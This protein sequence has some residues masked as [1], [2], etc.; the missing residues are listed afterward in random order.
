MTRLLVSVRDA[1]EARIAIAGGCDIIDLKEPHAGPLGACT[2]EVMKEVIDEVAGRVPI[3]AACGE[4]VEHGSDFTLLKSLPEGLKLAKI[5]PAQCIRESDISSELPPNELH[6]TSRL[7]AGWAALPR[8]IGRV[9]VAYADW[10]D[11]RAP[12]PG[13]QLA[14]AAE[15]GCEYFLLDTYRKTHSVLT[16]A[17]RADLA[18]WMQQATSLGMQTVLA[19]SLQIGDIPAVTRRFRPDV[20]AVRGAV[21]DGDRAGNICIDRVRTL[22]AGLLQVDQDLATLP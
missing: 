3:S 9:A 19:G 4:L 16:V 17:S 10:R 13:R 5:G 20:I 7:R 22:R 14:M 21:C 2:L 12:N 11:C 8:D 18:Q 1:D 6:W 15:G